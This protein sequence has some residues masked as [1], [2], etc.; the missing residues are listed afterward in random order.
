MIFTFC[1]A[2]LSFCKGLTPTCCNCP[3]LQEFICWRTEWTTSLSIF[4]LF[5]K[6]QFLHPP[7]PMCLERSIPICP[8]FHNVFSIFPKFHQVFPLL[9]PHLH[10]DHQRSSTRRAEPSVWRRSTPFC[11]RCR[12]ARLKKTERRALLAGRWLGVHGPTEHGMCWDVNDAGSGFMTIYD[13]LRWWW[14]M[15]M[16]DDVWWFMINRHYHSWLFMMVDN[17]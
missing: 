16:Y 10:L 7:M 4:N 2:V 17:D 13:D 6:P 11:V 12:A 14:C 1:S 15:M 8:K 5:G 9:N 3:Q